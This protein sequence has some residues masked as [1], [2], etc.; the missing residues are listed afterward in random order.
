MNNNINAE[1]RY[2][3]GMCMFLTFCIL[4]NKYILL[5]VCMLKY[6]PIF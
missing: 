6:L 1:F 5:L 2:F 3:A 4:A